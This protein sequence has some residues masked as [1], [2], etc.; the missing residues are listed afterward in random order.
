MNQDNERPI[1]A[2]ADQV[3]RTA[4][5]AAAMLQELR[6]S[7]LWKLF[8]LQPQTPPPAQP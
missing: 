2:A 6:D 7:K 8:T 5:L 4:A 1:A 3:K